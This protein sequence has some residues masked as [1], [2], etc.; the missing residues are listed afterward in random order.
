MDELDRTNLEEYL[1]AIISYT[2]HS[3]MPALAAAIVYT[4]GMVQVKALE[5][6]VQKQESTD[7]ALMK[8][9]ML[10]ALKQLEITG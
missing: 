4:I 9:T 8:E 5:R 6:F 3:F 2:P 10:W 1:Q 7:D